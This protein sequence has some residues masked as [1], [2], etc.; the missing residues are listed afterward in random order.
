MIGRLTY[1]KL[2]YRQIICLG[3]ILHLLNFHSFYFQ[4]STFVIPV[5]SGKVSSNIF[6]TFFLERRHAFSEI[7]RLTRVLMNGEM[8]VLYAVGKGFFVKL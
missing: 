6:Q 4:N 7:G 5:V 1:E 2:Y 8:C 3:R